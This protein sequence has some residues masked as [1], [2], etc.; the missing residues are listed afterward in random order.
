MLACVKHKAELTNVGE[1]RVVLH[2][3]IKK[4]CSDKTTFDLSSTGSVG[5]SLVGTWKRV[6]QTERTISAKVLK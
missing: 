2:K 3:V 4:G 1:V 5:L 6:V